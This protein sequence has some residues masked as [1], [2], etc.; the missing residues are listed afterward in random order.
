MSVGPCPFSVFLS[1]QSVGDPVDVISGANFDRTLDFRLTGP[2]ELWWLR[3]YDSSQSHCHFALGWGQTHD[4]DRILRLDTDGV[5]Y[6]APLGRVVSFPPLASDGVQCANQGF[7]LHRL[8]IRRYQVFHHGE[9]G[10]EFQFHHPSEPARLTRLFQGDHQIQFCYDAAG[11]LEHIIDSAGRRISVVEEVTGRIARLTL[12]DE[13]G[14]P[15]LLLISY[16]YDER[17][18]LVSTRND[19]GH[20]YIFRYDPANR[21]VQRTG[22]AGFNFYFTYDQQ[23]RCIKAVG[24]HRL[25]GVALDYAIAGQVTKVTRAD[26]GVWTY[27]FDEAGLTQIIDPLGSVQR[28]VRDQTGR[29]TIG[30][31]PNGN[32]TRILY[33]AAGAPIAKISPLGHRIALPEDPNAPDPLAHPVAA[34]AVEYEYGRLVDSRKI[35]LPDR[36]Q[37]Q[38]LPLSVQ[39]RRLVWTRPEQ[40]PPGATDTQFEVRPLG[41]LWWPEPPTGRVFNDL[42]K[43]T[44]QYDEFG[45]ERQWRYDPSGNLAEYIDFD[46]GKWTYEHGLWHFQTSYTNPLEAEVRFSYT[47]A[48]EVASC[49]DAGGTRSE[50]RYDLKDKLVEVRRHGVVRETYVRDAVGNLIAKHA[51]DGRELLRLEIGPGNLPLKRIL[52]SGDEHNLECDKS[53]RY[54]VVA[55]KKDLVQFA[56][57]AFGNRVLDKRNSLGVAHR[58]SGLN[59]PA[60]SVFFERFTVRYE[61]RDSS[62]LVITDP[63]GK[64]HEICFYSNGLVERRFSNGSRENAQYDNIGRCLFKCAQRQNSYAWS[65]RYHWSGEGELRWVED[66]KFSEVRYEY[67]QAH[68]LRRRFIAGR[69]EDYEMDPADNLISQPGLSGV[70]LQ[71]GNRLKTANG[72]T[73]TYNDRNHIESRETPDGAV[74]YIYDSRDQLIGVE[75]PKGVWQAEYDALKRRARKTWAG[76]TTEYYWNTDQLIAEVNSV[77]RLRLYI[78]ADPLA[79]TPLLF[80]DYDSMEAPPESAR[81]YF[82]F[83]DQIGTPCLIENESRS[84]IWHTAVAPFGQA[85]V[86]SSAEIEFNLRFAGHYFDPELGLHYNRFRHYDPRLG[87]Y[88][89][90]DPWGIAGGVNLYAYRV[91]PLFEVDVRG[92]GEENKKKGEPC[93][94]QG[95]ET[96]GS[97]PG[98][99]KPPPN[100]DDLWRQVFNATN[101][102]KV[103][104]GAIDPR[105]GQVVIASSGPEAATVLQLS[106]ANLVPGGGN[107]N[108][109]C[110]MPRAVQAIADSNGGN[111]PP[112]DIRVTQGGFRKRTNGDYFYKAPCQNCDYIMG[113][114][115]RIQ[116]SSLPPGVPSNLAPGE[117]FLFTPP[118]HW[119]QQ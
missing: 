87:R 36:A 76:Q 104:E 19:A 54:L 24:D 43:L 35:T 42:G 67:D 61:W 95:P 21:L 59:A 77:G 111:L 51:S 17:G 28:F 96:E 4:F 50:Y 107:P 33:D 62:R 118:P 70:T 30:L 7:V 2:L 75:M 12:E 105:T 55:T 86:A 103:T 64:S 69:V 98:A 81:R 6:V 3:H 78:Y 85:E 71:E 72:A 84:D 46:G 97:T 89:Q 11:R 45:R 1:T 22:R 99:G 53:G 10:M 16:Q 115:S 14:R 68:R 38:A 48:G 18:N 25:H 27:L 114:N 49:T 73:F 52:T 20:G 13:Q 41:V 8:S 109:K 31:D 32:A 29:V 5:S 102:R 65:R 47:S 83:T 26:L 39:A 93:P 119:V 80:L 88:L 58:F 117:E 79:L 57:D 113:H 106:P 60:E 116:P 63:G 110:G 91:N 94:E 34:N 44:R 74:R 108:G 56:Y 100:D 112:G 66:N 82:V 9:P 92:L 90:S 37:A 101:D 40:K 23:G 15:K